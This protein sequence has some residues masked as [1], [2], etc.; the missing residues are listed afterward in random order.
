MMSALS[1]SN[2]ASL[3]LLHLRTVFR[4]KTALCI[5]MNILRKRS[6]QMM[7]SVKCRKFS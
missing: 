7:N 4:Q 2:T 5:T 1:Y 6:G 3:Q